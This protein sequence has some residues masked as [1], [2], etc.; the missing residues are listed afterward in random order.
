MGEFLSLEMIEGNKIFHNS[1]K[2]AIEKSFP[3]LPPKNILK[4]NEVLSL[5]ISYTIN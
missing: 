5:V 3:I 2:E 1:V 4:G